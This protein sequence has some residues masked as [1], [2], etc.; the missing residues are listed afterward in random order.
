MAKAVTRLLLPLLVAL[1][2]APSLVWGGDPTFVGKLAIAVEKDVS[3]QLGL[4]DDVRAKL[5]DLI[6]ER[7]QAALELLQEIKALSPEEQAQKL[8]PFVAESEKQGL[9][10]LTDA[11]KTQLD[12][13][14]LARAGMASLAEASVATALA[15]TDEQKEKVAALI[16]ERDQQIAEGGESKRSTV[17]AYYDRKLAG[18]LTPAQKIKWDAMA[19]LKPGEAAPAPGA[20]PSATPAAPGTATAERVPPMG[21]DPRAP[22]FP[23]RGA[24]PSA[25]PAERPMAELP[26]A[27]TKVSPDG[28][29]TFNLRFAPWK[30]TLDWFAQQADLSLQFT[31]LPDGTLNYTDTKAYTPGEAIDILNS[32]LLTK[33]YTLVRR[34]R[35]LMVVNLEDGAPPASLVTPVE[36]KELD[37]YGDFE[38]VGVVFQLDKFAPED[39]EAEIKKLIG[40]QGSVVMLPKARQIYVTETAGRLR[41]IRSII[42]RVENPDEGR[43]ESLTE[44]PLQYV[45]VDDAM[46]SIRP[47]MGMPD[48]RNATPDGALKIVPDA[49]AS[50]LIVSGK[51]D[52]ITKIKEIVTLIDKPSLPP[53]G[54]PIGPIET[55]QLEVYKL[56]GLD[57]T[58]T[59][60]V[61]QTLLANLPDV[62]LTIDPKTSAL[63]ALAR[64][65]EHLTIRATLAQLQKDK[66]QFEVV[67]LRRVDPQQAVLLINKVFN[68]GE[69][70][71]PNAPKVE[72][73]T[74]SRQLTIYGTSDQITQI[75]DLLSKWGEDG[76]GGE[77]ASE[78]RGPVRTIAITG[79]A[80]TNV[81][82]QMEQVWPSIGSRNRI[83][84]HRPSADNG[85]ARPREIKVPREEGEASTPADPDADLDE[86]IE[87][88]LRSLP[89]LA[90]R[91]ATESKPATPVTPE[92]KPA[93]VPESKSTQR[94][95]RRSPFAFA[96]YQQPAADAEKTAAIPA[97]PAP[98][99]SPAA[100]SATS[101]DAE[102]P[103]E[104]KPAR[105][106]KPGADIVVT[107][108]PNGVV[109]ASEDLEALDEFERMFRLLADQAAMASPTAEFTIVYL[110]Y[111]KA[112]VAA[113][114]LQEI[115]GQASSD[116]GGGGGGS[117][118]GNIASMALGGGGG[119]DLL[120]GLFGGGMDGGSTS[121]S[122]ATVQT[123]GKVTVI[124]DPRLNALIV[125]AGAMDMD[126]IEQMLKV[127]DQQFSP[128]DVQLTA[129]P[130]LIEVQ[131]A[132]A[133]DVA[134]VV[135]QVY[136]DR[137]A[138]A[139]GAQQRQPSPEDFIRALRGGG[140]GG[141]G[142]RGGG[143]G[144]GNDRQR[145]E[146]P[147]M[148][149]GV[150]KTSN[151]LI[152]SAP[153]PLFKQVEELVA[154][155]DQAGTETDEVSQ[156]VSLKNANPEM[157]QRA[158]S[159]HLG[160][161]AQVNVTSAGTSSPGAT[162]GGAAPTNNNRSG[163]GGNRSG[164]QSFSGQQMQMMQQMMRSGQGGGRG[165]SGNRGGGQGGRGGR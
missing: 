57:P 144:G 87:N 17:M 162:Q 45:T 24:P 109:I 165:G 132:S 141:R 40:P 81:L 47:L 101:A 110:K 86:K 160:A 37:K 129:P 157:V 158:V 14:R 111:A 80:A 51:P 100:P 6:A 92:T 108:G 79:S 15:L 4:A 130:R 126:L 18:I 149:I 135:R 89:P 118:F 134:N 71:N 148:T 19:G 39:A 138:A 75:R 63:I 106:S 163:R 9:A 53:E 49:L 113:S 97:D 107:V 46:L 116:S 90:P 32:V 74:L 62:R 124:P 60:Q 41:T 25:A 131:Y 10:L 55:P 82:S 133:E 104:E 48:D 139:P 69:G 22:G 64:P 99:A 83:R 91:P 3:E 143:G 1:V 38:L 16:Q 112:E 95:A 117:L 88:I 65:S 114:L 35:M 58:T 42:D 61:M 147:K 122:T 11:Q 26:L 93:P 20:A 105:V 136:A 151:S 94:S 161:N 145:G 66:N 164:N 44:I 85:G 78:D 146:A 121:S 128:E 155:I 29:I 98:A 73:D 140:G 67:V 34:G 153:D 77:L 156:V 52:K 56:G 137:M 159:A 152:V 70:G 154:R 7:E 103:A 76:S 30:E 31:T 72:A 102:K 84:V 33:G 115:L 8:A 96:A 27:R 50:R 12:Q 125:Q 28:K 120:G 59:L 5:Q 142:G 150:D 23:G 68:A 13:I 43:D 21:T 2:A 54:G 127:I 123:S 119:G 36:L